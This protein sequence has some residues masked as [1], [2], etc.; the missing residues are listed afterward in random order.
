MTA[1]IIITV[2]QQTVADKGKAVTVCYKLQG[3]LV[4][5]L[6]E[7]RLISSEQYASADSYEL[8]SPLRVHTWVAQPAMLREGKEPN[9][10]LYFPVLFP[11]FVYL[12]SLSVM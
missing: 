12:A 3:P 4:I 1:K 5:I 8:H 6:K 9:T 10:S 11:S 7:L 2:C